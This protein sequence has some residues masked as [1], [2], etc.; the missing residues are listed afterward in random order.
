MRL[1]KVSAKAL[2]RVEHDRYKLSRAVGIRAK[3]ISNGAKPLVNMD[4]KLHKATDIA[5][6]EIAEGKLIIEER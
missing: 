2:E 5:I 4:P 1:E 3:E 6:Y